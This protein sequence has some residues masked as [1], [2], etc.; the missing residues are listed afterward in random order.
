MIAVVVL[1]M[2]GTLK[3]IDIYTP[4]RRG[5][6]SA[7]MKGM[8]VA[9]AGRCLTAGDW[10][11]SFPTPRMSRINL[12][13]A[14]WTIIRAGQKVK[15]GRIIYLTINAINIPLQGRSDGRTTVPCV[16]RKRVS[17]FRLQS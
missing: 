16:R 8:T 6:G 9:E 7:R 2:F 12:P 15:E 14:S 5:C 11:V 10:P 17:S 3:G 13:A 4:S 1:L